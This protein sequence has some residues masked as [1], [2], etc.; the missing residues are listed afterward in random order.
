MSD[1]HFKLIVGLGNPGPKYT[2][3]RHNLGFLTL[4]HFLSGE[5]SDWRD[6]YDGEF[7]RTT[8]GGKQRIFVKPMSFMNCSGEVIRK[9]MQ[10]YYV[11]PHE[12]LVVH[13]EADLEEGVIRLKKGGGAG[14]HNGLRSMIEEL[15]SNKFYRLRVGTGKHE[16]MDLAAFLLSKSTPEFLEPMAEKASS[17]L[18]SVFQLGFIKAQAEANKD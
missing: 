4:D 17:I 2:Y 10:S 1:P 12:I 14:G 11:E 5:P 8:V 16:K 15:G 18:D 3:T 7:I 13:D 6:K 9:Y